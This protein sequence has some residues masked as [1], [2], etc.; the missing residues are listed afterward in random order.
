[1]MSLSNNANS[2][3]FDGNNNNNT[4]KRPFELLQTDLSSGA[5]HGY[6]WPTNTKTIPSVTVASE[7]SD[8]SFNNKNNSN[9]NN[10]NNSYHT[11]TKNWSLP[12]LPFGISSVSSHSMD[13]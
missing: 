12:S 4:V 13:N 9:N 5:A 6:P 7:K 3:F 10:N 11:D 2:N 8:K 1:M